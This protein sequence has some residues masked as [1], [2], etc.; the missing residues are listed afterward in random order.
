MHETTGS[1]LHGFAVDCLNLK[2]V[3]MPDDLVL[4]HLFAIQ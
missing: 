3:H 4:N 1:A 2:K